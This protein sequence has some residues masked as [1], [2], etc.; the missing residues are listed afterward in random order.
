MDVLL[1]Q[2]ECQM[3]CF[4]SPLNC[5]YE[6]YASA[7]DLDRLFGSVGSFFDLD[8]G[9]GG[10][11]QA[12]PPFCEDLIGKMNDKI[13]D[14]LRQT[15]QDGAG[16]PLMFIVFVPAWKQTSA[17]YQ[18][19]LENEFLTRH[20]LLEQG[21]HWYTEGTQHRR[22]QS[23]RVAS[24]DTSILFYQNEAAKKKW[25]IEDDS[26]ELLKAAFCQDP[27]DMNKQATTKSATPVTTG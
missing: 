5:R 20:V 21:K 16:V 17:S 19:L 14:A 2:F 18:E 1:T 15:S 9:C 13:Q 22:K 23:F 12:N 24:F 8:F 26:L 4:A 10:C 25:R 27:G 11:F 6:R 7:F 3:E